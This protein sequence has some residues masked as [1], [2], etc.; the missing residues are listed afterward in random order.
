MQCI[1]VDSPNLG[2]ECILKQITHIGIPI[3]L[4]S[5]SKVIRILR[6]YL[7]NVAIR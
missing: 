1:L 5:I 6:S 3:M 2:V 7:Y 4:K